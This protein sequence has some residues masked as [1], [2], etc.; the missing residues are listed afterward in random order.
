MQRS[1][2]MATSTKVDTSKLISMFDGSGD[3]AAWIAKVELVA[4]LTKVEDKALFLP[5]YLEGGALSLYLELREEERTDYNLLTKALTRAYCDSEFAAYSKFRAMK[6]TGGAVDEYSNE[7]RKHAK[8]AGF[9]G[10]GLEQAV[11]VAFVMG[12]PD[13]ISV[14]LQQIQGIEILKVEDIMGRARILAANTG[15]CTSAAVQGQS[16]VRGQS[17]GIKCYECEGPH[18]VRFCPKRSERR[19]VKCYRCG[20][21]HILRFCPKEEKQEVSCVA[22]VYKETVGSGLRGVPVIEV[23]VNGR[24]AKAL[25]DTGCSRT[26][27]RGAMTEVPT[28]VTM[29]T[30]FD[31]R[32]VCSKGVVSAEIVIGDRQLRQEVM[33]VDNIVGGIDALLG[34]DTIGQLG[35]VRV[36]DRMVQFGEVCAVA[37]EEE[38]KPD[39]VDKDFEATF[40]GKFWEVKYKWNTKG[41]PRLRNTVSEYKHTM[42][43]EKHQAYVTEIERWIAD[44]VLVPWNGAVQGVIPLMAVEQVT[45]GKVRPVMDFR[46]LNENVSC[47]TGDDGMDICRDRIREWRQIEG[48]GKIVDLKAAY[49]QIRVARELWKHQLVK[50]NGQVY[51]LTRVGFGLSSAPRIMTAILKTVLAKEQEI[52]EGTS[53]F[54]D[55]ILVETSKVTPEAVVKH[56]QQYGLEAKEPENLE[57]GAA[58]GLKL[59]RGPN[60]NNLEFTRGNE[61]PP[62]GDRVSRKELFSVCGKLVGHYPIV[63]WLRVACSY[64][65]RHAEGRAWTDYVGDHARDVLREI[66]E[67]V[68]GNDPVRGKWAVPKVKKGS[69]WCD[70]SKIALG[71][72]VN[73]GGVEVED[74]AWMR[75]KDDYNH[76]NVAELEAVLRGVNLCTQWGL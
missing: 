33:V 19:E 64:L 53:S 13:H 59:R 57:G 44:G 29:L 25:V 75:K 11:K 9:K 42:D 58:L 76:I 32:E 12:F 21:P 73:I 10:E 45:K 72:V 36:Q 62:V 52:N 61:I 17:Q 4:K 27:V 16:Q 49:L 43:A 14:E 15:S 65:K 40:N 7:I 68:R 41:E 54:M 39:I 70:A 20:G 51:A 1:F 47:H 8:N 55:D 60:G 34:M 66:V 28:G 71:V 56:L 67:E 46:E 35:G 22:G 26:M 6:W 2:T 38:Q 30:A 24:K 3:L 18:R 23:Q 48:E 63:G 69:V 74:A 31:G 37:W 50:Y 5:L